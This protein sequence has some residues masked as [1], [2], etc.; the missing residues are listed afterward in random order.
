MPE[1][2]VF[3]AVFMEFLLFSYI[4]SLSK[5]IKYYFIL[6]K[7]LKKFF[8]VTTYEIIMKLLWNFIFL[9]LPTILQSNNMSVKSAP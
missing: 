1:K 2:V 5:A 9:F 8:K 4:F 6:A 7:Y 3:Q